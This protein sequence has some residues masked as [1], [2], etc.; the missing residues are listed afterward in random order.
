MSCLA[1]QNAPE[2]T[3]EVA[4]SAAIIHGAE[5]A[6]RAAMRLREESMRL[7]L[8]A[9]QTRPAVYKALSV[10]KDAQEAGSALE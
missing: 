9:V 4:P 1:W 2:L 7:R 10:A 3:R 8:V 5:E 6:I